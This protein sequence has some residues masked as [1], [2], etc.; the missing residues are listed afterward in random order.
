MPRAARSGPRGPSRPGCPGTAGK[1][2]VACRAEAAGKEGEEREAAPVSAVP[3][4]SA[5]DGRIPEGSTPPVV[6]G[7]DGEGV[8]SGGTR[9]DAR[10]SGCFGALRCGAPGP[11][12]AIGCGGC[13]EATSPVDTAAA[14]GRPAL[15]AGSACRAKVGRTAP[16]CRAKLGRTAPTC[17][18]GAVPGSRLVAGSA[19]PTA[20]PAEGTATWAVKRRS[21]GSSWGSSARWLW[22][23][24]WR[25]C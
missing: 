1:A 19:K 24:C 16:T 12:R 2:E 20:M 18:K 17:R 6:L 9:R 8:P 7:R 4:A 13:G 10:P 15:M 21:S 22:K 3:G 23:Q 14:E 11:G 25:L 5:T